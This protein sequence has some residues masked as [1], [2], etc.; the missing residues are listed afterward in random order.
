MGTGACELYLAC[1]DS[2]R[3]RGPGEYV[4]AFHSVEEVDV[5]MEG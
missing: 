2:S 4:Q 5:P 1:G 3:L